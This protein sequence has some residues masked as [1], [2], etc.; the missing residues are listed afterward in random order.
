MTKT[1]ITFHEVLHR[2]FSGWAAEL[3]WDPKTLRRAT[4]TA[5]RT[6][7][8]HATVKYPAHGRQPAIWELP[9]EQ[10]QIFFT[11]E[12]ERIVVRRYGY[13]VTGEPR[14]DFDGGGFYSDYEWSLP[15]PT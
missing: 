5:L 14:D 6:H 7:S 12:N 13:E 3:C 10:F 15:M 8:R 4:R 11:I 2:E 9:L 1:T